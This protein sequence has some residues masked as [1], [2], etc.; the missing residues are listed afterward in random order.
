[1]FIVFLAFCTK[2]FKYLRARDSFSIKTQVRPLQSAVIFFTFSFVAMFQLWT[3]I[4]IGS[5]NEWIKE[6][7]HTQAQT[8]RTERNQ[9]G[10]KVLPPTRFFGN[11]GWHRGSRGFQFIRSKIKRINIW[12]CPPFSPVLLY[13][14][15][16]VTPLLLCF[17]S[18]YYHHYASRSG[19]FKRRKLEKIGIVV[20]E[21]E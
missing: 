4:Y 10:K 6:D 13:L 8:S 18:M 1:M 5:L 14:S 9:L 15:P 2:V 17:A 19:S 3:T 7:T 21:I 16:I 20:N 11:C 12:S